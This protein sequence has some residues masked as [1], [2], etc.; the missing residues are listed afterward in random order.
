M[1]QTFNWQRWVTNLGKWDVGDRSCNPYA[2]LKSSQNHIRR[3]NLQKYLETMHQKQPSLILVGEAL[4]Y[5]GGRVTGIPF[6]SSHILATHPHFANADYISTAED[7]P[8]KEATASIMWGTL[9]A[10]ACHP[11]LWNAYPFHPH[12]PKLPQSNRAPSQP[13][14]LI[15]ATILQ[16][17]LAQFNIKTIVAV[18]NRAYDSLSRM[19]L[20]CTKVRH[21]SHGGKVQFAAGLQA[22]QQQMT[23]SN[24]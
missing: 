11:L 7:H 10:Q 9:D 17:L 4:G 21:P 3:H 2:F 19:G 15:G 8:A 18:G 22:V 1:N 14:L 24:P 20:P 16:S 23:A 13:E 6:V 12:K 5:R